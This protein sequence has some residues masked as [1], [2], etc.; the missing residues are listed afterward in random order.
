M[1]KLVSTNDLV[2]DTPKKSLEEDLFGWEP[3]VNRV[4][5]AI[6]LKAESNHE[7]FTIGIYGKWGEGKTSFMNM[8]SDNLSSQENLKIINYNPW[9]FKDQE[10]LLLDFFKTLQNGITT[11]EVVDKIKNMAH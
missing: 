4:S 10:S 11:Q 6:K 1:K 5:D 2:L 3:I 8:V 7:C 9:L